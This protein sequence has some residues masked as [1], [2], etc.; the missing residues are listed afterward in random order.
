[1]VFTDINIEKYL[2]IPYLQQLNQLTIL[3]QQLK[4]YPL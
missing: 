4:L 1:M 2:G 3:T